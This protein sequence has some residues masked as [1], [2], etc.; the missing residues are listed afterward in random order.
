MVLFQFQ[1]HR[2]P[3]RKERRGVTLGRP[4]EANREPKAS[5]PGDG[6]VLWTVGVEKWSVLTHPRTPPRPELPC[7][8]PQAHVCASLGQEQVSR[9]PMKNRPSGGLAPHPPA[10]PE[11]VSGGAQWPLDIFQG[12]HLGGSA[13]VLASVPGLLAK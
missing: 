12:K 8:P 10:R 6:V 9:G 1:C 13:R 2:E 4:E 3:H 11:L 7:L 5:Y